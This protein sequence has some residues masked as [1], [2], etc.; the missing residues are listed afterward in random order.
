MS[1]DVSIIPPEQVRAYEGNITFNLGPM[2]R[3][4]GIHPAILDGMD[5]CDAE[6][7]I[8]HAHMLLRENEAYFSNFNAANGWGI[9]ENCVEFVSNLYD[10]VIAA[11]DGSKVSFTG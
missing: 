2:L 11:E 10:A 6:P 4:A 5:T 3:R 1:Y 7:V 9:Y 8:Y